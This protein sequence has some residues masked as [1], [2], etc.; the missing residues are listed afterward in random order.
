M[1]AGTEN[2]AAILSFQFPLDD[3]IKKR[4]EHFA[5]VLK[6]N[7]FL[8]FELQQAA[9][10]HKYFAAPTL[11][12]YIVNVSFKNTKSEVL[13]RALG[14]KGIWVSNSSA[15]HTSKKSNRKSSSRVL[16][17]KKL[18]PQYIE[19]AIRIGLSPQ[20]TEADIHHLVQTIK[21]LIGELF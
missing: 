9:M 10:A 4:E 17:S 21:K 3:W 11:S 5:T 6:L 2:T 8:Q 16:S 14:D 12:P 13:V 7:R 18:S 15:C 19:G 20:N 1:R